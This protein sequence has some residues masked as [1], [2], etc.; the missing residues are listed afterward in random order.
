M[1]SPP[2]SPKALP[3]AAVQIGM[4]A[5]ILPPAARVVCQ[6][7]VSCLRAVPAHVVELL[8]SEGAG[9][10]SIA[11]RLTREHFALQPLEGDTEIQ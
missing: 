1:S 8:M 7:S 4:N 5:V 9:I 11:L 3:V 2:I 6:P 10:P